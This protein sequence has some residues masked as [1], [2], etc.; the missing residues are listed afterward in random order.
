[1]AA[2]ASFLAKRGSP[3]KELQFNLILVDLIFFGSIRNENWSLENKI[4]SVSPSW[5]ICLKKYLQMI[6]ESI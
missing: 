4:G 6:F 5:Y 3:S 1:M 2:A